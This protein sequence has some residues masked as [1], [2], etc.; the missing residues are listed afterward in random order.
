MAFLSDRD[1]DEIARAIAAAE[2]RTSGELVAVVARAS[3]HYLYIP[4]LWAALVALT[5]PG[6][7]LL[8]GDLRADHVYAVQI[9]VFLALALLFNLA[10]V[11]MRLIPRPVRQAR[12]H[13]LAL[14]QFVEQNLHATAERTGVLIF[15]S[16][17]E[18][19]VEIL[20]DRGIDARVPAEAW[21]RVVTEFTARLRAGRVAEGFVEA[22]NAC[23]G[24]LAEHFPRPPGDRNEL[25]DRL[26]EI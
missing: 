10:P 20:A 25:P 9:V 22:V 15:V 12:A 26:V 6:P 19:H 16:V 18:H 2:A 3:D 14:A 4:L 1:R 5:I 7:L 11:K 17:A 23:G 24:L 8:F 21:E 13:R